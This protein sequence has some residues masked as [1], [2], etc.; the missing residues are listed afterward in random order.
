MTEISSF[1]RVIQRVTIVEV[2]SPTLL[3]S[4]TIVRPLRACKLLIRVL[5]YRAFSHKRCSLQ[6]SQNLTFIADID[7]LPRRAMNTDMYLFEYGRNVRS[8]YPHQL[9][10]HLRAKNC[11]QNSLSLPSQRLQH[12]V[13]YAL[14]LLSTQ[15]RVHWQTQHAVC[16]LD[17]IRVSLVAEL[18][19]AICRLLVQSAGI[20]NH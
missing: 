5:L 1:L 13:D 14:L 15:I 6:P 2:P 19:T 11:E 8:W 4:R 20:I 18:H 16:R 17:R 12:R 10:H 3:V 7:V 9:Q